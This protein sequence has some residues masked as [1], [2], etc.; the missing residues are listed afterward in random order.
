MSGGFVE[1][2]RPVRRYQYLLLDPQDEPYATFRFNCRNQEYLKQHHILEAHRSLSPTSSATSV[3]HYSET[4]TSPQKKEY[5][6]QGQFEFTGIPNDTETDLP[7]LLAS[8]NNTLDE[9]MH[10]S[11]AG[12]EHTLPPLRTTCMNYSATSDSGLVVKEDLGTIPSGISWSPT[13]TR[14]NS[15]RSRTVDSWNDAYIDDILL[16]CPISLSPTLESSPLLPEALRIARRKRDESPARAPFNKESKSVESIPKPALVMPTEP[17]ASLGKKDS[18]PRLTHRRHRPSNLKL[19]LDGGTNVPDFEGGRNVSDPLQPTRPLSPFTSGGF[20]RR[21]TSNPFPGRSTDTDTE[22]SPPPGPPR[23][24][25]LTVDTRNGIEEATNM[26]KTSYQGRQS[27]AEDDK[28]K[29]RRG[30][31]S[32]I[33]F[34]ER[35]SNKEKSAAK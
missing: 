23:P 1:S 7:A 13:A 18:P 19:T 5:S 24:V 30:G 33:S 15:P 25:Q 32:L 3:I 14:E 4:E 31:H 8:F 34:L 26:P 6:E 12:T 11:T 27:P 2:G 10:M 28:G 17:T 16:P 21:L 9:F 20:L 35:R 29:S 22:D